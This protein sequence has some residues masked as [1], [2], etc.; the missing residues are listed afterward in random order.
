MMEVPNFLVVGAAKSGT[1]S[2]D[3]YLG[4]H[5][6][7]YMPRKKEA[8]YFSVPD[9]PAAF[10]GPGDEGMNKETIR[11]RE[12][13]EALFDGA[14]GRRAVGESS[15]FYLYYPGTARRIWQWNPAMRVVM[16]L[17]NPVDR[18]YSAYMHLIRDGRETLSFEESLAKE[19]ERKADGFE[20]MWL[21]RELGLYHDQVKRYFDI[22]PREQVKVLLYDD[23]SRD[24]PGTVAEVFRFLCVDDR[25]AVDT[26]TRHNESGVPKSRMLFDFFAKSHPIKEVL[27]PLI[28][29]TV[30]ERLGNQAKSLLLR[31]VAMKPGTRA[32]LTAFF[33]DD[34]ARL[35][36]L[37]D[38]D[39]SRWTHRKEPV[40][41]GGR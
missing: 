6:D 10:R 36:E 34:I 28:P 18:A 27:K 2:L 26:E 41:E 14:T 35:S 4:Q 37:L 17:R 22:F 5:P 29:E 25:A 12:R 33:A 40:R 38:R 3:R 32:E 31:R 13:Y 23:F 30:R 39:L 8:H 1:S 15:V 16:L 7:I 21:Y 24:T 20:P 9:F 19:R 11:D